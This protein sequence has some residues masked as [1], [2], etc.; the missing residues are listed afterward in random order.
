MAPFLCAAVPTVL[1][2]VALPTI[3]TIVAQAAAACFVVGSYL[4]AER[5]R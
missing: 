2:V 3:E 1:L 5:L 4:L